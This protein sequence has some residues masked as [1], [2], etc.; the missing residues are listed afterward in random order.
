MA[1]WRGSAGQGR[2]NG[3]RRLRCRAKAQSTPISCNLYGF[4]LKQSPPHNQSSGSFH[5]PQPLH[6]PP[7]PPPPT[8]S[9]ASTFHTRTPPYTPTLSVSSPPSATTLP[10]STG[11]T[12]IAPPASSNTAIALR[13]ESISWA[14]GG[15]R[16]VRR[17]G[18]GG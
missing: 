11:S 17:A 4:Q 8:L 7:P 5:R 13:A 1:H 10:C 6:P 2:K 16:R 3:C 14:R 18:Q 15:G 12:S 9:T